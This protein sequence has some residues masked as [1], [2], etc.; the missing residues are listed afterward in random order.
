MTLPLNLVGLKFTRWTVIKR[1]ENSMAGKTRWH[2]LC[3]CGKTTIVVGSDLKKNKSKS[4]GCLNL[5]LI[6]K[7]SVTH[8]FTKNH[9][10]TPE[11]KAWSGMKNR[12]YNKNC[13]QYKDWGGRGVKVCERWIHSFELF[14]LDRGERPSKYHS[15]DRFPNNHGNYEPTNCRWLQENNKIRIK[16]EIGG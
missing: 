14:L 6:K 16:E 12:C 5:E 2:C 1:T 3:E 15:L 8:G 10:I 13:V 11:Y 7:I 9:V 4:C